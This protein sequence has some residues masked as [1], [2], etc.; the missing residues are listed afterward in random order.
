MTSHD[1]IKGCVG[2]WHLKNAPSESA[3]GFE[4]YDVFVKQGA[5]N[6]PV[7]TGNVAAN[8]AVVAPK[9]RSVANRSSDIV[10]GLGI[11]FLQNG[12]DSINSHAD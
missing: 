12:L 8:G 6:N 7:M 4:K 9:T 3:I 5:Y 2:K 11:A 10:A 1:F